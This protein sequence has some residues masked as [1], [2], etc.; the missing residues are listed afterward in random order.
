MKLNGCGC[1]FLTENG[2]KRM[3][4][5]GRRYGRGDKMR[6][7]IFIEMGKVLRR[8]RENVR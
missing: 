4:S 5:K 3:P 7:K 2:N 8:E 6:I 1:N